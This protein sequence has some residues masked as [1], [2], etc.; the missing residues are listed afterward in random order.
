MAVPR[1]GAGR[2]PHYLTSVRVE[3]GRG[4]YCHSN[5]FV[6]KFDAS[7]LPTATLPSSEAIAVTLADTVPFCVREIPLGSQPS[8]V[9]AAPSLCYV[10][11]TS[12]TSVFAS[13]VLVCAVLRYTRHENIYY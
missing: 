13:L 7:L 9:I 2:V 4:L 3:L 12:L 5:R 11:P 1:S 6:G 10:Y 8:S